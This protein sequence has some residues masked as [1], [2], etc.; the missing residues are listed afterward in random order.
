MTQTAG[1]L[2]HATRTRPSSSI[3]E[4]RTVQPGWLVRYPP[5]ET[6]TIR[7]H[8]RISRTRDLIIVVLTA[9]VWLPILAALALAIKVQDPSAPVL[10]KQRRTG[11][12][13]QIINVLKFRTM[14]K[15]AEARKQSLLHLNEREWPA[16]KIANDPRV[17]RLGK[18]LRA[19][20]LDELPQMFNVIRGDMG[21]VGPRPTSFGIETYDTWH[22]AR[23]ELRPGMTGL[24]QVAARGDLGWNDQVRLELAY[25]DRASPALDL[26]ILLRTVGAVIHRSGT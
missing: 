23:L 3:R 26:E 11:R 13:G 22:T 17:T 4:S 25:A 8:E 2:R 5:R 9:A 18:M 16:F 1:A 15:D 7:R 24:W 12:D 21:L 6:A 19:T 10:F 14:V 20:S